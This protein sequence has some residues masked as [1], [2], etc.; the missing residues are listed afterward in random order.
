VF[1]ENVEFSKKY[2]RTPQPVITGLN[3]IENSTPSRI[4]TLTKDD[5]MENKLLRSPETM[6]E[7]EARLL[8]QVDDEIKD[9]KLMIL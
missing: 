7:I 9:S 2:N 4:V 8:K 1:N 5:L 6:D 3:S